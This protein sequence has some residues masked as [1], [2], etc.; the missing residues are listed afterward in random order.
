MNIK[1]VLWGFIRSLWHRPK[2]WKIPGQQDT[3]SPKT[4]VSLIFLTVRYGASVIYLQDLNI[5]PPKLGFLP[6]NL[7]NG[8]TA[9]TNTKWP[10]I[11]S[12]PRALLVREVQFLALAKVEATFLMI[13]PHLRHSMFPAESWNR[14]SQALEATIFRIDL[15]KLRDTEGTQSFGACGHYLWT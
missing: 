15:G 14:H 7:C 8:S 1:D 12:S 4:D 3:L 11:L 10:T 6:D 5:F 9:M 13:W 2:V